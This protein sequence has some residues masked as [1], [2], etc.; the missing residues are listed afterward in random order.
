MTQRSPTKAQELAKSHSIRQ[1]YTSY[2]DDAFAS[3]CWGVRLHASSE[4]PHAT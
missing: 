2:N 1:V 3:L 4:L